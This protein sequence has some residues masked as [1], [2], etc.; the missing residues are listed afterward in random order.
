MGTNTMALIQT[1]QFQAI[2]LLYRRPGVTVLKGLAPSCTI[3]P[4]TGLGRI[5]ERCLRN[6]RKSVQSLHWYPASTFACS[7]SCPGHAVLGRVIPKTLRTTN[8]M[9]RALLY[10]PPLDWPWPNL[11]AFLAQ[12][13]KNTGVQ[14]LHWCPASTFAC[15]MLEL[16][17]QTCEN[18]L[19]PKKRLQTHGSNL[20]GRVYDNSFAPATGG[21]RGMGTNTM[22]LIQT[23][24]FQAIRLL[25][26]RPGVTVLKGLAPS[27]T[28]HPWTGL[29][30]IL[31]R[32]LRNHRK[33]VQRLHWC[34]AST[35][36]CS[37]SSR[38]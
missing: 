33:S 20:D 38:V 25:Y 14:R 16:L 37:M 31:E 15:S 32:C 11:G 35:F 21:A 30:R 7:M 18:H 3:H 17:R 6:H 8:S 10:D 27:C 13:Q 1:C 28:I 29:G 12:R 4:W 2:R 5:L 34:P 19:R 22:A 26:R 24:Q 23:C 9:S 36:A